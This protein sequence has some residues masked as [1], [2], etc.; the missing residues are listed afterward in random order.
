[1]SAFQSSRGSTLNRSCGLGAMVSETSSQSLG[2]RGKE[3]LVCLH[4]FTAQV[5]KLRVRSFIL[6]IVWCG[7][8]EEVMS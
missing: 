6:G 5:R 3:A 4:A 8:G 2:C 1:M 7:A